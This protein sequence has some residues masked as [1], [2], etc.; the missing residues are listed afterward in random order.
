MTART[1]LSALLNHLYVLLP[2]LDDDKHCWL[3]GSEIDKLLARG[4][5]WLGDHPE[6]ELIV[7]R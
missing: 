7:R 4:E 2:V 5:G 6:R 1:Q 3:N